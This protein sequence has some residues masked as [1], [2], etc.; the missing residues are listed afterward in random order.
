M[1]RLGIASILVLAFGGTALAEDPVAPGGQQPVNYPQQPPPGDPA[2]QQ[3]PPPGDPAYQQQPYQQQPG[4]PGGVQVVEQQQP[5]PDQRPS[6]GLEYGAHIIFPIWVDDTL[7]LN[8][9]LGIQGRVG[10]EFGSLTTELNIGY[11]FNGFQD[12][13]A[14]L[15]NFWIGAGA[16][17]SFFNPSALVPFVGAGLALNFWALALCV[18][19][20]AGGTVCADGDREA[21]LSF[22]ALGG[23]AWEISPD[24]AV[25]A[26]LQL[27][28]TLPGD[29][30]TDA[31][32]N[33]KGY[34]YISP[35]IGG[36]LYF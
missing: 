25:E 12:A 34:V 35:F 17:L 9:G 8:P 1:K 20:G 29:V 15:T 11:Q 7:P 5:T 10:W 23:A 21:T 2:Y 36:T 22:N 30:F 3:Q 6:R 14:G 33:P 18:D 13:D 19:D 27:N 16:R 24:I 28:Y 4:Q 26:G 31:E 32:G